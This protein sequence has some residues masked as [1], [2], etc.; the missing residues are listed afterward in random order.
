MTAGGTLHRS[1]LGHLGLRPTRLGGDPAG[2]C[3]ALVAG[4]HGEYISLT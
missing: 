4:K 2:G 3:G 1:V